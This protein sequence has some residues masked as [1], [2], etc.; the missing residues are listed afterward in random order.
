M[1]ALIR[2]VEGGTFKPGDVFTIG[3]FYRMIPNPHRRWWQFWK[4]REVSSG[5][6]VKFTISP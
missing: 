6:L 5:E 1:T 2:F 3:G 4:P